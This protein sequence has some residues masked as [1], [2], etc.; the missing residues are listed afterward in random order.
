MLKKLVIKNKSA[1]SRS[2]PIINIPHK[3]LGG[4]RSTRVSMQQI[5]NTKFLSA[6]KRSQHT[7]GLPFGVI[8]AIFLIVVF[9]MIA[10]I[11]VNHFLNIGKCAG[12]GQFYEDLQKG[13]DE[14]WTTQSSEFDF[15]INLPSKIEKVCFANLSAEINNQEDYEQIERYSVYDANV[16][17]V[18]PEKSCDMPYKLI[19]HINITE[20]TNSKNPYCVDVGRKLKI[21]KTFYGKEVLIE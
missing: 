8:F 9:I 13:V 2:T 18:P 17:L 14:A 19:K 20:I 3:I 7:L 15:E 16:F 5:I 4:K 6:S 11:A 1:N 21:K 10:F 12:V